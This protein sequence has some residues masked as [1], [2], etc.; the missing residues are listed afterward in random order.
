[1]RK[2]LISGTRQIVDQLEARLRHTYDITTE[3]IPD[4]TS[5]VCQISAKIR[6]DWVTIC[7]FSSREELNNIITMFEVNYAIRSR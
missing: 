1:M 2:I 3:I 7:S 5:R 4:N 6:R